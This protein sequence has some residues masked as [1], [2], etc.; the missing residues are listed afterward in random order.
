MSGVGPRRD[1]WGGR[2]GCWRPGDDVI[3]EDVGHVA[4]RELIV[5]IEHRL[6]D[7]GPVDADA[8][9]AA[10]VADEEGVVDLRDAAVSAGD[11]GAIAD[12][13]VAIG[14][15]TDQHDGLVEQN[16]GATGKG[17]Q[18]CGHSALLRESLT[19]KPNSGLDRTA[20]M[21]GSPRTNR[22]ARRVGRDLLPQL[23]V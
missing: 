8:V 11:L 13:H 20:P 15:A 9:H 7:A 16:G 21:I 1:G 2:G 4:D 14:M 18:A 17:S 22:S 5:R 3:L 10:Q 12:D 19:A 23:T 6:S